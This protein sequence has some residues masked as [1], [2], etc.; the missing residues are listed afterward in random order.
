MA[1]VSILD[2]TRAGNGTLAQLRQITPGVVDTP[3]YGRDS[4]RQVIT[5]PAPPQ[6]PRVACVQV[7]EGQKATVLAFSAAQATGPDTG[8]TGQLAESVACGWVDGLIR[9]ATG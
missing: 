3:Q 4:F 8:Y 2:Q 6:G 7:L 1:V 9:A 5:S